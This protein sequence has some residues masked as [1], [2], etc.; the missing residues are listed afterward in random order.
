MDH[1]S[2]IA[3][4][5]ISPPCECLQ[6]SHVNPSSKWYISMVKKRRRRRR[7]REK[8]GE[9]TFFCEA[10]HEVS[11]PSPNHHQQPLPTCRYLMRNTQLPPNRQ[12][13]V[14]RRREGGENEGDRGVWRWRGGEIGSHSSEGNQKQTP[15]ANFA[16]SI[17]D[18]HIS[19]ENMLNSEH[20]SHFP[21]DIC[22]I[23]PINIWNFLPAKIFV[24]KLG[25]G[26]DKLTYS[27]FEIFKWKIQEYLTC[28]SS[29]Y[30]Q[31]L[32]KIR[33]KLINQKSHCASPTSK[34][35]KAKG[36]ESTQGPNS[37]KLEIGKKKGGK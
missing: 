11:I 18:T 4:Y 35:K 23:V 22:H 13:R 31:K 30:G 33:Q 34:R 29:Y 12:G 28:L 21:S 1:Y 17:P 8:E 9:G 10:I 37:I 5:M 14:K 2:P 7:V 27:F 32:V 15:T 20:I 3:Q 16:E 36:E 24:L 19:I 6:T 26:D 25:N